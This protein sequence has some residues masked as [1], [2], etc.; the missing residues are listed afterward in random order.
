MTTVKVGTDNIH[1]IK[2]HFL[3]CPAPTALVLKLSRSQPPLQ[4]SKALIKRRFFIVQVKITALTPSIKNT[5]CIKICHQA[6]K[7][8]TS[9]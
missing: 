7:D 6:S 5:Q 4:N 9:I 2:P 1:V 8:K 3:G